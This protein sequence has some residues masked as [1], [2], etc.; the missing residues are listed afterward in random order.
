[1]GEQ[2]SLFFVQ[3]FKGKVLFEV[4]MSEYASL[5]VGG[6]AEVMVFPSDEADLK[7]LLNFAEVKKFPVFILGGGTN[8]LVRDRGLRGI[9]VNITEGFKDISWSGD[10]LG[11]V[12]GAGLSLTRLVRRTADKGLA[13][14]EFGEGI[15][16]SVGGAA[17]MN[18]GAYGSEMSSVVEALEVISPGGRK[19]AKKRLIPKADI[20]YAYRGSNL[21]K[22]SVIVRVHMKFTKST[23]EDIEE[24]IKTYREKRRGTAPLGVHTAGSIFKNPEGESAGKLIDEAGLKGHSIGDASISEVHANYIVNNGRARSK[25][26]LALIA[27]IRDTVFRERGIVLEPE[28]KVVGEE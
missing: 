9:V 17:A 4:P 7:E 15:P 21:P 5:G 11:A 10:G 14:L 23:T 6:A 12:I 27:L 13:G 16:G 8:L 28:I 22:G 18:A 19:G 1:M 25:D 24:K 2:Y 26:I 20:G 3:R